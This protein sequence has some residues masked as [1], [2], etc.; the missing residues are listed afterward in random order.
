MYEFII[1]GGRPGAVRHDPYEGI[2]PSLPENKGWTGHADC[3]AE[4]DPCSCH[5]D[6]LCRLGKE[7]RWYK[8]ALW[9]LDEL[10]KEAAAAR[11]AYDAERGALDAAMNIVGGKFVSVSEDT[12]VR[13]SDAA[14]H[15]WLQQKQVKWYERALWPL[16]VANAREARSELS[17]ARASF[18]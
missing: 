11:S 16:I 5:G 18:A 9:Y 2:D 12:R 14:M 17:R 4:W 8:S 6:K 3:A 7:M 15:V 10:E 1:E 13:L